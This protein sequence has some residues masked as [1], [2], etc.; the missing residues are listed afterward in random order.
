MMR[1]RRFSAV[2][3]AVAGANMILLSS[4]SCSDSSS[5]PTGPSP[6]TAAP[7]I[8]EPQVLVGGVPV[9][10]RIAQGNGQPALFRVR[11][12]APSGLNTVRQVVLQYSQPGRNHHGGPMMGGFTGTTF[13]YDDGTHGDDIAGD[14][15]YQFMDPADNIGCEGINAAPGEYHYDFWCEDIYGQ[16]SNTLSLTVIRQ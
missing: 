16:R 7:V 3:F 11:V 4:I 13:C 5:P 14:G 6:V 9:G 10:P 15:V 8:S 12:N 2:V 1:H